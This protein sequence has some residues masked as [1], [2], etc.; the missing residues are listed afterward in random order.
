MMTVELKMF[1]RKAEQ[2][3]VRT[4]REASRKC[5]E[6]IESNGLGNSV[7]EGGLVRVDGKRAFRVSYNGRVWV[8]SSKAWTPDIPEVT[9]DELDK[10][11]E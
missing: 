6:F 5:R 1:G 11:Q 9:G 7:W 4:L 2:A 8:Y 3:Q 10:V